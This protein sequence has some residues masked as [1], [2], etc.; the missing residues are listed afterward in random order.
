MT[1]LLDSIPTAWRR[2][3]RSVVQAVTVLIA[4]SCSSGWIE[5]APELS[6]PDE[7]CILYS[8]AA[9]ELQTDRLI[10]RARSEGSDELRRAA[11][12]MAF[13]RAQ[14]R[15]SLEI[16]LRHDDSDHQVQVVRCSSEPLAIIARSSRSSPALVRA[17]LRERECGLDLVQLD[18]CR[19][20]RT[21]THALVAAIASSYRR[22]IVA[23]RAVAI[24]P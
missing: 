3:V 18:R 17:L 24:E 11:D 20:E 5:S 14:R 21:P 23:L 4:A 22:D 16:W 12:T 7:H 15:H 2:F 1:A 9:L 10:S 13:E 6:A 8:L 19:G